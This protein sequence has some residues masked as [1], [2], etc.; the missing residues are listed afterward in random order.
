MYES[1]RIML[2]Y[3]ICYQESH[4]ITYFLVIHVTIFFV[5]INIP[6]HCMYIIVYIRPLEFDL[7]K[8][9]MS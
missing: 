5:Y 6:Q 7:I 8:Y 4:E 3:R 9:E 1:Y 2:Y